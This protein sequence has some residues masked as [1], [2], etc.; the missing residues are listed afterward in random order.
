MIIA[1][2][3][4]MLTATSYA[5]S[6]TGDV[7]GVVSDKS[8]A[9][10]AGARIAIRNVGTGSRRE[11]T[12]DG[13]GE[14][15]IASLPVASYEMEVE[16][17][18]FAKSISNFSLT[19]GQVLTLN[20]VLAVSGVQEVVSVVTTSDAVQLGS[21]ELGGLIGRRQILQLPLNG[22]NLDQLALLEPGV[23]S[24]T[25]RSAG[26][27]IHGTQIN[28][29][30]SGGRSSRFL[31]D[32]TNI[33]DTFNNGIGSAVNTFLGVDAVQEFRVLTNSYAAEYGEA[34]GGVVSIVTKSGTKDF[35]GSLFEFLR[36]DNLDARNFF[37][38]E[39]PEFIRNQFGSAAS[40][41]IIKGR[42]FFFGSTEW[43]RER[44]GITRLTVV[45]SLDARR[46]RLP[47]PARP[48]QFITVNI[49]P[50]VLPYLNLFPLPN[51]RDFGTGLAELAF[52]FSQATNESFY[53]IRI[54]H[55]LSPKNTFFGRYT[56][57]DAEKNP[58][59][60]FPAWDTV[61]A[62]R[63]Q[64]LTLEDTHLFTSALV[65]T[66]RFSYSRTNLSGSDHLN[67]PFPESSILIPGRPEP[68]ISIGGMPT[69]GGG[70]RPPRSSHQLQNLF[71]VGD[72]MSLVKGAHI[73]KWG[74]LINRAQN[75][76]ET[77]SYLGGRFNFPGIQQFLQGRPSNLTIA[78][79][80]SDPRQYLF[81]TRFGAYFQ[82]DYKVARNLTLNL[83]LRLEFSTVPTE[84]QGRIVG[85][86]DPL[87]DS[88]VTVGKLYENQ[89]QNWAPRIG[90][91]WDP[92]GDGKTV[93]R[94]GFGIFYDI[95]SVP[96]FAQKIN[97][98]PPFNNRLVIGN[99]GLAPNLSTAPGSIDLSL[100]AFD[101][102]TPHALHYN[103]AAERELRSGTVVTVAY[104]GSRGINLVR[105]GEVNSPVPQILPDGRE[106]FAPGAPR[107]NPKIGSI[108]LMRPDG[109]SWY[110]A[111]QLKVV[112]RIGA[113]FRLQ[114]SYTLSRTIDESH[115]VISGDAFGSQ[116]L[117]WVSTRRDLDRGLADFHR[118][119][120][121]VA[122]WTWEMPY[123]R[124][125][126]G[127][128][129]N[130]LGGWGL[131]GIITILSGNP[132][133][134]GIQADFT[135]TRFASDARGIDRPNV[136]PGF[137]AGTIIKGGPNQYFDPNAF[138]LPLRG[139]I[140]NL[141]R[142]VLIGPGLATVDM[143][144][145]KNFPIKALGDGGRL[146]L[147]VEAFN[148]FNRANF[149]LP[150]RILFNGASQTELPIGNA[151]RISSTTTTSRQVQVGL[152][153]NW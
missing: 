127:L 66:L 64:F 20:T 133:T 111:L 29:N 104:A 107:R 38:N 59:A 10:I 125:R 4:A 8:G 49:N 112:T 47:D 54:D 135:G 79:I 134:P 123:L 115:G 121:F 71:S 92:L 81:H 23:S 65:N 42:T 74:V 153:L 46:G 101:W 90:L 1:V 151:G 93:I 118:K 102:Q 84:D 150:A 149:N 33:G 137:D 44:L 96:F 87:H 108:A 73:L 30:G 9:V 7:V 39:K 56:F 95:N 147:R 143:A 25:N 126:G 103:L 76:I 77:K 131:D 31:L 15:R 52:P 58:P 48:G 28:I 62:S 136:K 106:F 34:S 124:D 55:K 60:N 140:G 3:A 72:D 5:Q 141:G 2:I 83:G 18:G 50:A 85:L 43:L 36:N 78:A 146:Q 142:N 128:L 89:K 26:G 69:T 114:G 63:N 45:P 120:N 144:A 32:G 139:T 132:F 138:E 97:G 109:N 53:Q 110:N 17:Q 37:D 88:G 75:L 99:P 82:D 19:V 148:L 100:P 68:Q 57:D 51:G 35:H 27:T 129:G 61:E 70:E 105:T 116:S 130:A 152:R 91:A 22:R 21:S 24:T 40:G 6:V 13:R 14:F 80:T 67:V 113:D 41:P 12:S 98:N 86:P 122:N 117:A 94:S 145:H 11:L 16:A 119:H